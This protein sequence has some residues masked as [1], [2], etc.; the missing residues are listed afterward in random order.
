MTRYIPMKRHLDRVATAR[1]VRII[2]EVKH[3]AEFLAEIEGQEHRLTDNKV[4]CSCPK[5]RFNSTTM[6]ELR[7][8]LKFEDAEYAYAFSKNNRHARRANAY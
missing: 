7:E 2:R 4:H 5:C 1:K 3:D 8:L 6:Q